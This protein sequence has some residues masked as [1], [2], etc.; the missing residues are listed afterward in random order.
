MEE[1]QVELEKQDAGKGRSPLL[2]I[3]LV[4]ITALLA[5]I[6]IA[7]LFVYM[8]L[9]GNQRRL[10]K[11]EQ[12]TF[13]VAPMI[14]DIDSMVMVYVPAG[15]FQMGS[16]DY[17]S[18]E[19]PAHMVY[20]DAFWIDQT[21]VTNEMFTYFVLDAGYVTD[22][23]IE[24]ASKVYQDFLWQTVNGANWEHP[25]G[26][27]TDISER[28]Q[29]PVVHVSWND[30]SAY[31]EWAGRRLP[32]EAEWEKAASWDADVERQRVYPWGNVI[33]ETYANYKEYKDFDNFV[34]DTVPVGSYEKGESF[35]GAQ[36]MAGNVLEW[37]ADWYDREYY[38]VSPTSNP[39]GP[40]SGES[41]VQRGGSWAERSHYLETRNRFASH[42]GVAENTVGF[43]CA[44]SA[45][46]P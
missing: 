8:N 46:V 44:V 4:G 25:F 34:G 13:V 27:D 20:L 5:V 32:T 29:H 42:P 39:L 16:S 28:M 15:E 40:S 1:Q 43:R 9:L 19:E 23:E 38:S 22:A 12:E 11:S 30:A 21:E 45:D 3:I 10:Y 24:E 36:D 37:V 41:R 18:D 35:Y 7:S 6:C 2:L 33:D 31:C 17:L 26:V 14:S